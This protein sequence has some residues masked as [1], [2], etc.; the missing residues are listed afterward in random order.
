MAV[1]D[2][3]KVQDV[4]IP[5]GAATLAASLCVPLEARGVVLF[6]HGSGSSRLSPRNRGVA[7]QL[8][9]IGFATVLADLLTGEE[10]LIDRRTSHLRFDIPFLA[11]RLHAIATWL[12]GQPELKLLP[13]GYF[14]A[15]TGA[16]AALVAAAAHPETVQAIVSRGGRPDLAGASL[17][18]VRA[19]TLLLVG[20]LDREVLALNEQ[21]LARLS[22]PKQLTIVYGA[23]HLFEEPGTLDAVAQAA[24]RWFARHLHMKPS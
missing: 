14:G 2:K 19:P 1:F 6:A 4:S 13:K 16:A 10:E 24:G 5:A 20:N 22:C 12:L 7:E 17:P 15:S 9:R 21:A 23:S 18:L 3:S 8:G 11:D